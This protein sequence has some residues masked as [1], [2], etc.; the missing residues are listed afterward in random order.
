MGFTI[1][2]DD[3]AAIEQ[4]RS[5]LTVKQKQ[6]ALIEQRRGS[7]A[8][9]V[10][11]N[12][13]NALS[14]EHRRGSVAGIL[15]MPSTGD[16]P[17]APGITRL[18]SGSAA[19]SSEDRPVPKP[20]ASVRSVRRSPNMGSI[21]SSSRRVANVP[22]APSQ[23]T[24]GR[25][26]SPGPNL[27]VVPSQPTP[28]APNQHLPP[29]PIS[30]ARRRAGQFGQGKNK[31]ADIVISPREAQYPDQ[32][33]PSIQSAPPVP[34]TQGQSIGRFAMTLPRLPSAMGDSQ[35][36]QR[37][38]SG[39]V[40]PTPTGLTM[41]RGPS[42]GGVAGR[43]SPGASIPISTTLVPPT[44]TSLHRAGYVGEKSAFLAPFETF[45][46]SLNDS[47]QLKN[48]L[49]EQ[50]Q[51]SN[52]LMQSLQHQ[53]EKMDEIVERAVEKKMGRMREE[54]SGLQQKVEELEGALRLA[55]TDESTR[56]P[57]VDIFGGGKGK[58]KYVARNGITPTPELPAAYT[59]PPVEPPRPEFLRRVSPP[60]W[61][62][63]PDRDT[64]G[65]ERPPPPAPS[66]RYEPL[67]PQP[68]ESSQSRRPQNQARGGFVPPEATVKVTP[69]PANSRSSQ[70]P[71]PPQLQ[72]RSDSHHR[73]SVDLNGIGKSTEEGPSTSAATSR[74]DIIM[75]PPDMRRA[76]TDEV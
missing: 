23:S 68:I 65:S 33:A 67:R 19:N 44:P 30:F 45:Y 72:E 53:Q 76:P 9:V 24:D 49:S 63:E 37:V 17:R 13:S 43:S 51:K 4:V 28:L 31:P 46:D 34:H 48:W 32:L 41:Q 42:G 3:P 50:L 56:R 6:K 62:H 15:T 7:V 39:R 57:S 14:N 2:R 29:P 47:K 59:F 12:P 60:G 10:N 58:N 35:K 55:R 5:M 38:T 71:R 61:G 36:I 26:A 21:A 8:G 16:S 69:P 75:S 54:I 40:P 22:A 64:R 27:V 66:C 11:A 73:G 52:A 20:A 74:R 25:P 70:P 18:S 1:G